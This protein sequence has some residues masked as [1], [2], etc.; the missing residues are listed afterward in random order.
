MDAGH[1]R[2]RWKRRGTGSRR[3]RRGVGSGE[4]R[5][6]GHP[7]ARASHLTI[8]GVIIRNSNYQRHSGGSILSPR[9]GMENSRDLL[10]DG[11][12]GRVVPHDFPPPPAFVPS[13][14]CGR[15]GFTCTDIITPTPYLS[16]SYLAYSDWRTHPAGP[17]APKPPAPYVPTCRPPGR[18]HPPNLPSLAPPMSL[19]HSSPDPCASYRFYFLMFAQ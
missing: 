17:M 3:R 15:A 6:R 11:S 7:W 5:L 13:P 18:R 1:A 10:G 9:S 4:Q 8:W 16:L 14:I 2:T 19:S 12:S